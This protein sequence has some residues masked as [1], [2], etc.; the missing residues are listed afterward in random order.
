MQS[1][2]RR[3]VLEI[4]IV[5]RVII[6]MLLLEMAKSTSNCGAAT[7]ACRVYVTTIL[8]MFSSRTPDD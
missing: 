7:C 8:S 5:K 4:M 2:M 6:I 3:R 1:V